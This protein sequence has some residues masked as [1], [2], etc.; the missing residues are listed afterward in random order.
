MTIGA[1]GRLEFRRATDLEWTIT[2]VGRN[3]RGGRM[4]SRADVAHA[5]LAAVAQPATRR[6]EVGIAR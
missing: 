1:M 6:Q 2:A 5:M 3:L 4:I